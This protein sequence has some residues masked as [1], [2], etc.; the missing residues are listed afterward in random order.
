M[1]KK[2]F[3]RFYS[4]GTFVAETN[5]L[6]IDAWNVNEA[7]KLASTII[8]RYGAR[9]Y[10]FR[11]V[12]RERKDDELDSREVALSP[13][14]FL[15]GTVETLEEIEA[16]NDPADRILLSN[17]WGNG[18]AAVVTNDNSWRWTQ[19]LQPDDVVLDVLLPPLPLGDTV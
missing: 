14:Y 15:G 6:P 5:E 13:Q 1:M 12:T 17:M 16:R 19:P 10:G 11:F 9:P 8:Q 7:V 2:H 4:P 18:Y 3:V